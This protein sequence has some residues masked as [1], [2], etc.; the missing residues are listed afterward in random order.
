MPHLLRNLILMILLRFLLKSILHSKVPLFHTNA[1]TAVVSSLW[2]ICKICPKQVN[3]CS[4]LV[5]NFA[6]KEVDGRKFLILTKQVFLRS[7]LEFV[8]ER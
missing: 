5:T 3:E 8:L 6:L 4:N 7:S 1:L 2:S